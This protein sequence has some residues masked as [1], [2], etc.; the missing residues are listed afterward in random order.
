MHFQQSRTW[1]LKAP[2]IIAHMF[3]KEGGSIV[4]TMDPEDA[5]GK[6]ECDTSA[7]NHGIQIGGKSW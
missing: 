5:T 1:G 2:I 3:L 6:L 7:C 4:Y